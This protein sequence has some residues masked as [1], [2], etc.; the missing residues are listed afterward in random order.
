MECGECSLCCWLSIIPTIGKPA[1]TECKYYKVGVGCTVYEVRPNECKEF[2]CAYKQSPKAHTDLRP[3]NCKVIFERISSH[4]ILGT[5][6]PDYPGVLSSKVVKGQIEFFHRE[7]FSIIFNSLA[8]DNPIVFPTEG[9][10]EEDILEEYNQMLSLCATERDQL[11]LNRLD[12]EV[13]D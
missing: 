11:I 1:A 6:H 4:T 5:V 9:I 2:N 7:G 10:P 13:N 8:F 3:D 12:K